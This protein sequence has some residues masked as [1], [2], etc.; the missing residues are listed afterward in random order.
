[1]KNVRQIVAS[2]VAGALGTVVDFAALVLFVDVLLVAIPVSAFVAS[3]IGAVA[4]FVINKY[5]AFRDRTPLSWA[6]VLKFGGVA[7]TT[8]V[9]TAILMKLLAVDLHVP[10]AVAKLA[11]AAA[12]FIA[13]TYPAQRTLVFVQRAAQVV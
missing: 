2:G 13:W 8:A 9:L 3:A 1:M 5:V 10:Y 7:V 12:I 6:Q 4:C 11:S